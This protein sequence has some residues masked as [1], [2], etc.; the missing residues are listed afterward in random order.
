MGEGLLQIRWHGR[1]GQGAKT[2]AAMVAEVAVHAGKYG[3]AAPEY[4]AEREGAPI[5]AYTRIGEQ[6]IR[7]HDAI[8]YPDIVV[9]L[10]ETLLDTQNVEGGLSEDG[11]LLVN[12]ARTPAEVREA[13]GLE[14]C[15]I[16]T[17]E[18]TRIALEEIGRP[19]PNT[20][21][22]G[23][24]LSV[25]EVVEVEEIKKSIEKKLGGKL[26]ESMLKGNLRAVERAFEEVKSENG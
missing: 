16:Y 11:I 12:T 15:T 3:Q 23:A 13:L 10:D 8:Y 9:V 18:A 17:V 24:L 2:A 4:G 20:V 5:R 19:I 6:A 25:T 21:M 26:S 22:L 14:G 1:G 7:V